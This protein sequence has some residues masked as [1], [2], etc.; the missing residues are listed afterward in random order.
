MASRG[1]P[2]AAPAARVAAGAVCQQLLARCGVSIRSGVLALGGTT[3]LEGAPS[4][5]DLEKV[6][7]ASPLRT[8]APDR[9]GQLVATIDEAKHAGETFGGVVGVVARGAPPGPGSSARGEVGR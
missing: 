4:F 8:V 1:P 9:E 3:L 6:D 7:D 5:A 2:P